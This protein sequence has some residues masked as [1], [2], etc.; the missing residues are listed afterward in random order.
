MEMAF[1]I[2]MVLELAMVLK[3]AATLEMATLEVELVANLEMAATL[4]MELA[5]TPKRVVMLGM[6][7]VHGIAKPLA[8][9]MP[10]EVPAATM[11]EMTT[12]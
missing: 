7:M 9:V 3:I 2:T 4:E 11:L 8:M 1:K 5:P 6:A 12:V 10:L